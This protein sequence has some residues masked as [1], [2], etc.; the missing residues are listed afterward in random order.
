MRWAERKSNW[1]SDPATYP[2]I[3][4]LGATGVFVSG[5][6]VYFLTT[7]PDVQ[8]S[9]L[10]RYVCVRSY[11]VTD[12]LYILVVKLTH[13]GVIVHVHDMRLFHRNKTIRDWK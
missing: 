3:A 12:I 7:A 11:R 4:I 13:V 5:F 1:L 9:P 8:I 6:I 2:L 10:K